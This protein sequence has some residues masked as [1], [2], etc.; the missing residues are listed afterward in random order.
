[1]RLQ[2]RGR[3]AAKKDGV[4]RLAVPGSPDFLLEGGYVAFLERRVEQTAV[5]VA[6]VADRR[7][8]GNVEIQAEHEGPYDYD[9]ALPPDQP[10][11]RLG[12]DGFAKSADF[13]W[14]RTGP[15]ARAGSERRLAFVRFHK[16][17]RSSTP[18]LGG[19]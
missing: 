18:P 17:T 15:F 4:G 8:E 14:A 6:V 1:G 2:K 9:R 13:S 3:P 12:C 19:R 16:F 7:A 11:S 5:E 10:S